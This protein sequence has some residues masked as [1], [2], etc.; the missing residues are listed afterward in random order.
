MIQVCND[1]K[2]K[3]ICVFGYLK[4]YLR[5]KIIEKKF[6]NKKFNNYLIGQL[7]NNAIRFHLIKYFLFLF[8]VCV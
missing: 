1:K 2:Q 7:D 6:K 4:Y 5:N 8:S 3:Y